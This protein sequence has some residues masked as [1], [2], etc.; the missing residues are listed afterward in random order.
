MRARRAKK[1]KNK[2]L[3]MMVLITVFI[4][5]IAVTGKGTYA[6]FTGGE[7]ILPAESGGTPVYNE[8]TVNY[9]DHTESQVVDDGVTVYFDISTLLGSGTTWNAPAP[10]IHMYFQNSSGTKTRESIVWSST[11]YPLRFDSISTINPTNTSKCKTYKNVAGV[12]TLDAQPL[13]G[14]TWS[15]CWLKCKLPN[16]VCDLKAG[17]TY[18][19][20]IPHVGNSQTANNIRISNNV[21]EIYIKADVG[22]SSSTTNWSALE[23]SY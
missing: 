21:K 9:T 6:Y 7:K 3:I 18:R 14:I 20:V 5:V 11:S 23:V 19:L 22:G 1:S 15:G 10:L 4:G 17:D 12:R 8:F 16:S 13:G 2:N